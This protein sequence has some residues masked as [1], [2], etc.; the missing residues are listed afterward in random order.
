[1]A[2]AL[3]LRHYWL[4]SA[5]RNAYR[6]QMCCAWMVRPFAMTRAHI[7]T[8]GGRGGKVVGRVGGGLLYRSARINARSAAIQRPTGSLCCFAGL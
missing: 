2:P 4:L 7:I 5:R 1:M 3:S 6:V 8:R